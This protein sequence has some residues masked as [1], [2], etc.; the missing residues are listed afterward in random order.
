MVKFRR[1][2]ILICDWPMSAVHGGLVRRV[3]EA[4][5]DLSGQRRYVE[6]EKAQKLLVIVFNCL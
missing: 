5:A 1:T 4:L 3:T 2:L 6:L